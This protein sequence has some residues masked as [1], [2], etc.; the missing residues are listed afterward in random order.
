MLPPMRFSLPMPLNAMQ[1]SKET[2]QV[3]LARETIIRSL[4]TVEER[5]ELIKSHRMY[6]RPS[7]KT[8][9]RYTCTHAL[10]FRS[11]V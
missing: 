10:C 7:I 8:R 5:G 9:T 3:P 4:E 6:S 1:K 11:F 2:R